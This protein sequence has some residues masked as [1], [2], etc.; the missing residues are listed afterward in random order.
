MWFS[1]PTGDSNCPNCGHKGFNLKKKDFE[2][3]KC[4]YHDPNFIKDSNEVKIVYCNK[5]GCHYTN[6]CSLHG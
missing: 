4:G 2:C 3:P 6:R 5:C 1:A